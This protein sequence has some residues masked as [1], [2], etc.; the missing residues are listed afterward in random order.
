MSHDIKLGKYF[1]VGEFCQSEWARR[2]GV[3]I[4]PDACVI[5]A[6]TELVAHV[7]EPLRE[8][9]GPLH[10]LSGYRP[11]HVNRGVQGSKT[12]QHILGEAADI[13]ST[14]LSS[15][16]IFDLIREMGLP[17]DQVIEEF[18]QWVHVSY[19]P[20][21]RRQALVARKVKGKTVYTQV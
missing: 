3:V 7:L 13:R 21:N 2:N 16:E 12:S 20:K 19:G 11:P 15:K 17:F 6:L 8:K 1:T 10:I 14:T 18:G 5:G 9:T 4:T